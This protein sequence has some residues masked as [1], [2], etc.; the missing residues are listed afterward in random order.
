MHT[1]RIRNT[2]QLAALLTVISMVFS[3]VGPVFAAQTPRADVRMPIENQTLS[4]KT[5]T[6]AAPQATSARASAQG[7]SGDH[8]LFYLADGT[9]NGNLGGR[10]GADAL[11]NSASAK[12]AN[13]TGYH[14]FITVNASDE[15]EDMPRSY[16]RHYHCR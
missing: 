8:H 5:G 3:A 16:R 12:P 10:T 11:C 15:I 13:Y 1:K 9:H 7:P 6:M 14:A 2:R 4:S